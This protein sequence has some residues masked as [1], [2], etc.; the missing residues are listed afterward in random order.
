MLC[1]V[2]HRHTMNTARLTSAP[3]L[4][5]VVVWAASLGLY[6][7]TL[8]PTLTWG[9]EKTGV[10]GGEL[11]AAAKTLGV[12]HPPGYPTYTLLLR[13]FVTV[14]PVGDFAYRGNL[15]SAV[16][17][18]GSVV[19]LYCATLRLCR[20]LRPDS[21]NVAWVAGPA[22]GATVFAASP[23]FWSQS[24]MVEAYA[25][26]VLFEDRFRRVPI[27]RWMIAALCFLAGLLPFLYLPLA[28]SFQ[29]IVDS[30]EV[31]HLGNFYS[32]GQGADSE[33]EPCS[34]G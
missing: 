26:F 33:F 5:G 32:A 29:P 21:P 34:A 10:D 27:G 8:A 4:V 22:L 16:L 1:L 14:V 7:S 9:Y 15:L 12:P 24:V 28:S 25:M 13:L 2:Y 30:G 31:R 17:A 23:L 18:S 6:L 3:V 11:L 20:C 19:L